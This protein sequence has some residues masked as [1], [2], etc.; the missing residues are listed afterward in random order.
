V[1]EEKHEEMGAKGFFLDHPKE[2]TPGSLREDGPG[3]N[4]LEGQGGSK[5]EVAGILGDFSSRGGEGDHFRGSRTK[6]LRSRGSRLIHLNCEGLT[7]CK[8]AHG[9]VK[10]GNCKGRYIEGGSPSAK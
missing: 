1:E 8:W 10:R 2:C 6:L 7:R 5:E 3:K 4:R 9:R